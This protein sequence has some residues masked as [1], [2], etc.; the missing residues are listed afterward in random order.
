MSA[1]KVLLLD[2]YDSF[3]YNLF[4]YLKQAGCNVSVKRNDAI[5]IEAAIAEV[6]GI[7]LSPGPGT[8]SSA[9]RLMDLIKAASSILPMLGICLGHQ[10]IGEYFG[11]RLSKAVRPVHGKT[12]RIHHIK[13][14]PILLGIPETMEVMRYHSLILTGLPA[15]I[16]PLAY[17]DTSELMMIKHQALPIYGVQYHPESVLTPFGLKLI[18]NWVNIVTTART[19]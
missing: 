5:E 12:T 18:K 10:A 2:N 7:V 15:E 6:D 3:T 9:G 17:T 4:D 16:T 11:A 1:P 19:R 14:D 13:S 8:P